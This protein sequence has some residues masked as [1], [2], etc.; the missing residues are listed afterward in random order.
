MCSFCSLATPDIYPY[1]DLLFL[2]VGRDKKH[3]HDFAMHVQVESR[4]KN[5]VYH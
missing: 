4:D 3:Q 2:V 1:L 5:S